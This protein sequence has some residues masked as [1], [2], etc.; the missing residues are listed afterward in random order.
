MAKPTVLTSLTVTGATIL[1]GGVT[2][3]VTGDVAGDV[4]GQVFGTVTSY[5]T[6]TPAI[7]LTDTVA[8]LDATAQGVAATLAAGTAGQVI[9]IKA[10]NVDSAVT[11]VPAVFTDG[12]TI[13]F[14]PANEY[15]VLVSDGT[16]WLFVGGTAAI[17]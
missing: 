16:N 14:T 7:A 17:S 11:L 2:G 5:T 12:T 10:I 3:D 4:T 1:T 13:T 15:A 9:Y 8:T 6:A